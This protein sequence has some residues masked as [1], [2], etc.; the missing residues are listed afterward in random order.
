MRQILRC[1]WLQKYEDRLIKTF[2]RKNF[3]TLAWMMR[4]I[5][6][7]KKKD[8]ITDTQTAILTLERTHSFE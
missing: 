3:E 4:V 6:N 7:L 1:L 8:E 2:R 5:E